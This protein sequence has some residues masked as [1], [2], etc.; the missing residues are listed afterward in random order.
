M[1]PRAHD[2]GPLDV[3][4]HLLDDILSKGSGVGRSSD[5]DGRLDIVN[6]CKT[7]KSVFS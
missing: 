6:D 2:D 1:T 7:G 5:Q 4:R 3:L